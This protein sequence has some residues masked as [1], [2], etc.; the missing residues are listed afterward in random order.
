MAEWYSR[1]DRERMAQGLE[2]LEH[3]ELTEEDYRDLL[4]FALNEAV[5]QSPAKEKIASA[6]V[7]DLNGKY[8]GVT[9]GA[10]D[11]KGNLTDQYD[12][13]I[14][15]GDT[16]QGRIS[17]EKNGQAYAAQRFST[18][19]HEVRHIEQRALLDGTLP[20]DSRLERELVTQMTINDLYPSVYTRGYRNTISE[21]DADAAGLEGAL[22]FFDAHP[23]ISERYGFD[24]RKQIMRTDEYDLLEDHYQVTEAEPEELLTAMQDYRDSVYDDPWVVDADHTAPDPASMGI[25]ETTLMNHL[26]DTY[27]VTWSDLE[28][29]GNDERNVLLIENMMSTMDEPGAKIAPNLMAY[30]DG[31]VATTRYD[32]IIRDENWLR[33]SVIQGAGWECEDSLEEIQDRLRERNEDL[34]ETDPKL[35]SGSKVP[36]QYQVSVMPKQFKQA[37][38]FDRMPQFGLVAAAARGLPKSGW[39]IEHGMAPS[40]ESLEI[41]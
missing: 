10:K 20:V 13:T 30:R 33:E 31:V 41:N 1:A 11:A 4:E 26:V 25:T 22:A 27:G 35:L 18:V 34:Y 8:A 32:E 39:S 14:D 37:T 21:V 23:E 17:D 16:I 12:I 36:R 9:T 6:K 40:C 38:S 24:F 3:S 28:M 29:M 2:P 15:W 7:G 19:F 5:A